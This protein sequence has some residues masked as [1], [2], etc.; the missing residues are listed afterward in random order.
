VRDSTAE[1]FLRDERLPALDTWRS[2]F[3]RIANGT[4]EL[5]GV[6]V[7]LDGFVVLRDDQLTLIYGTQRTAIPLAAMTAAEKIQWDH[8]TRSRRPL[9][10]AEEQAYQQLAAAYGASAASQPVTVTGPLE[11]SETGYVLS[12]RQFTAG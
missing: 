10:A 11:H 9:E 2:E 8:R 4:Y 1:V 12:V 5:R 7:S 6:E 3:R